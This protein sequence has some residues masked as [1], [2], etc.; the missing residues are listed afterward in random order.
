MRPVS[1]A[2]LRTVTGSHTMTCEARVLDSFQ[3]GT[4]PDGTV[5]PIMDGSVT[6]DATASILST[7]RLTTDGTAMWPN[8]PSSLLGPY[9]NEVWVRRGLQY[10]NGTTEWVSLGYFRIQNPGQ[11]EAPDGPIRITGS[12]R[13]VGITSARLLAPRQYLPTDT[14]GD[15]VSDLVLDVYPAATIVWDD[16]T[17]TET[18]GRTIAVEQDRYGG[19]NDVITSRGKIFSWDY[20]GFLVIRDLPDPSNVVFDVVSGEGGV[21]IKAARTLTREGVHN[22]VVATGEAPDEG[23]PAR[24][25]AIDNNPDSPTYFYGRFGQEPRFYSSPLLMNDTAA[26]RAATTILRKELGL[27]YSV[28][29][30]FVPNPALEPYDPVRTRYTERDGSETHVLETLTVPLDEKGAMT[31]TTKEQSQTTVGIL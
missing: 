1:D 14:F 27:P 2:F 3:S 23:S 16:A 30:T 8:R 19:L 13:M 10:G 17:D 9:G 28:D 4:D 7:L 31:G 12:D 21:L 15:V 5:I 24:G 6:M 25:V 22:A 18:I 29:L 26:E 20:R 11:D